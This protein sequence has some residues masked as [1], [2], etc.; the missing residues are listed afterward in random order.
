[1]IAGMRPAYSE[2]EIAETVKRLA[3]QISADYGNEEI[4][5]V[6]VLKGAF[7]FAADLV[8]QLRPP[9]TVEFVKLASYR[10]TESLGT[11]AMVKDIETPV[12]GRRLLIVEDILDT[13]I[14]LDFLVKSLAARRPKSLKVCALIDKKE[15]R[16]AD[17]R[18]DYVGIECSCGFLVGYG[19][20]LDEQYRNLPAIYELV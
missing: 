17:V 4:L 1:M 11:V 3:N 2:D 15:R 14:T 16:A 20:D 6:V 18:A 9:V 7:M 8:R 5:L 10:G 12:E 19:L 13:G